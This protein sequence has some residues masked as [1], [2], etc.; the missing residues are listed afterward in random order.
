MKK[1]VVVFLF[2]FLFS[3]T[4]GFAK[5]I[6][7][8]VF[9]DLPY[10]ETAN[11]RQTL[12][13]AIPK[14]TVIEQNGLPVVVWIHGGGWKSGDKRSGHRSDRLRSL[15]QTGK[16]IGATVAYRLSGEAKWPAQIHDCKAA[17]RW[18][19]GNAKKYGIDPQRIAVWGSSAGGHLVSLL[20]SSGGAKEL[21]ENWDS[22]WISRAWFL[23]W[24]ITMALPLFSKWMITR[25]Q[26]FTMPPTLRKAN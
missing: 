20:G 21:E 19:R 26:S 3:L 13:L 25:A 12:D 18:L 14:E 7:V 11:P 16:F 23:Q 4:G 22:I 5:A 6:E 2:A 8:R 17:I 15:V 9:Q 1:E 10:A 24:S